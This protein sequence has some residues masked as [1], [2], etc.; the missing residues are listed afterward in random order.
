MKNR[1][2]LAKKYRLA[3]VLAGLAALAVFYPRRPDRDP[4]VLDDV[5]RLNQTRVSEVLSPRSVEELQQAI[6]RAKQRGL[7][8]SI[9]G[10]KHSQGGHAFYHDAMH[11][12]MTAFNKVL[13]FDKDQKTIHV[14]SGVTWK[15]I[16]E[17]VNPHGLAV[18]VM[19]SSNIFTVGGSISANAH[20][21]DPNYG[22]I[23]ETVRSFRLLNAEGQLINVNRTENAELFSLAI[24][25]FGLFGVIVDAELDLIEN[26]VYK[27]KTVSL[28]YQEYPEYFEKLV[29][30]KPEVGIHFGRLS[31]DSESL[32]RDGYV[33]TYTETD[34]RPED[35][36]RL[37]EESH[38]SR[39]KFFF[40]LSRKGDW[41][42][43]VRWRSQQKWVDVP[44]ETEVVARN[45]VMRPPIQFLDYDAEED[46]D[47][48][49]E[50]FVPVGNFVSFIDKLRQIAEEEEINLLSVT[51]RFVPASDEAVLS[52]ANSDCFAVV[53][54]INQQRSSD[55]IQEALHWTRQLVDA[56]QE[57]GGTYYLV[58]QRYPSA[59]QLRAVY[60]RFDEF[61]QRKRFYDEGELFMNRF[62]DH[63]AGGVT[64][65]PLPAASP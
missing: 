64:R 56:V 20:G 15:Q 46:T 57:C 41:G 55:G 32:L 1:W 36:S 13:D 63:Y 28:D 27:K 11:L 9:S 51:L 54:Y 14:Q 24:G 60:P 40:E 47:I 34:E 44:G 38:V 31:I 39:D 37:T 22:P 5:S 25:G 33:V 10:K 2:L 43:E 16:Q 48:L 42:K 26:S 12:D 21:R 17:H 58:Y 35:V 53:L 49:Q 59:T 23:I 45:N 6:E 61:V 7:K 4:L 65:A 30:G 52:Y 29:Q 18:A 19:Q 3:A 62:Y 8:V 50:Y